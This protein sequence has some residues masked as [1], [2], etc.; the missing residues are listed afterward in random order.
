MIFQE[1][2]DMFGLDI[3]E[4]VFSFK[5]AFMLNPHKRVLMELCEDISKDYDKYSKE[6]VML[7]ILWH[8]LRKELKIKAPRGNIEKDCG[9]IYNHHLMVGIYSCMV[10]NTWNEDNVRRIADSWIVEEIDRYKQHCN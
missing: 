6:N 9:I 10:K 5:T 3:P 7:S 8:V 4:I 1:F 2:V